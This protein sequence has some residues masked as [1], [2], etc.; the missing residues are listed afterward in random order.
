MAICNGP[1]ACAYEHRR[2]QATGSH[3]YKRPDAIAICAWCRA[4]QTSNPRC[5]TFMVVV[6]I[7]MLQS[8]LHTLFESLCGIFGIVWHAIWAVECCFG[9][10]RHRK[11]SMYN[12]TSTPQLLFGIKNFSPPFRYHLLSRS[13]IIS[14]SFLDCRHRANTYFCANRCFNNFAIPDLQQCSY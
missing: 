11:R 2:A 13:E 8:A 4:A 12:S 9:R 3:R 1:H 6:R 7:G 14:F 10:P 5:L